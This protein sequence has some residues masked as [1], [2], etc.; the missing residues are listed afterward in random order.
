ML[1][2]NGGEFIADE[3]REVKAVLN[4]IDLTAGAELPWQ[5]DLCEKNHQI[6]DTMFKRIKEDFP[7]T[8]DEVLL[9]WADM[10]KNSMLMV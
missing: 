5:N 7:E 1:N 9:A 6:V 4:I 3:V 10:A 8:E 2:D